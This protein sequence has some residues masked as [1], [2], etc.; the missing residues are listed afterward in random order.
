M[1]TKTV[2]LRV[3][4]KKF[5]K[6]SPLAAC[7]DDFIVIKVEGMVSWPHQSAASPDHE[8]PISLHFTAPAAVVVAP[9]VGQELTVTINPI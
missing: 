4:E 8:Y 6:A 9:D 7:K 3:T 1:L 5:L 2:T